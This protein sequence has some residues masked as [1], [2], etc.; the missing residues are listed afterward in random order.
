MKDFPAYGKGN[1]G[2]LRRSKEK[3]PT[4]ASF[5]FL[6]I[7]G[8]LFAVALFFVAQRIEFIRTE[9]RIRDLLIERRKITESILP[10]QLEVYNLSRLERIEAVAQGKLRLHDPY[11][12]QLIRSVPPAPPNEPS[13]ALPL[14]SRPLASMQPKPDRQEVEAR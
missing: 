6:A 5:R 11:P 2:R 10:L 9:R 12:S 1:T 8:L 13:A 7:L 14:G 3:L 4:V